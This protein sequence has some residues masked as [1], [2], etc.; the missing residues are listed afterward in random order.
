MKWTGQ[1]GSWVLRHN[2]Y[3]RCDILYFNTIFYYSI[4][5]RPGLVVRKITRPR[6]KIPDSVN[7]KTTKVYGLLIVI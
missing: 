3:S 5:N 7:C 4:S 1:L 2:Q 6:I